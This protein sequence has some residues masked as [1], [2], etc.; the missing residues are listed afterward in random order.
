MT[1]ARPLDQPIERDP[2]V[3]WRAFDEE[4][5]IIAPWAGQV[6]TLTEVAARFWQLAD[7]RTL[8]EIMDVLLD[9]F[10]VQPDILRRDLDELIEQLDER[11]LL[12][13]GGV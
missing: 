5:A 2:R 1:M 3:V 4:I 8:Q 10:E 11:K 7:G 13:E 12:R 6:H 9:E